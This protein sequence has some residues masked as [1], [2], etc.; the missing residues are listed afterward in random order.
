MLVFVLLL[1]DL[2]LALPRGLL[3]RTLVPSLPA[4]KVESL[5]YLGPCLP[6]RGNRLDE[7]RAHAR[8]ELDKWWYY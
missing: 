4:R 6:L 7:W 3:D 2:L 8:R 1:L 5:L